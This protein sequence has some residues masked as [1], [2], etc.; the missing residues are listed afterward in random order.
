MGSNARLGN[1][2]TL[3]DEVC[4]GLGK[5]SMYLAKTSGMKERFPFAWGHLW[6]EGCQS[7]LLGME[8]Q[9]SAR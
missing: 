5:M 3:L 9:E 2:D 4:N 7:S 1:D 8:E 6:Y